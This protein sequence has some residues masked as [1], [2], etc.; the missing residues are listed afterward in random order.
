MCALR[1]EGANLRLILVPRHGERRV[2]IGA[3]LRSYDG[4]VWAFRS[5]GVRSAV[6]VDVYI[7][8]TVGELR[9]FLQMAD[10]AVIGKSFPPHGQGQTPVESAA[11]GIPMIYG[12][13]MSNFRAVCL[14]LE[15]AGG[16]RKLKDGVS[17]LPALRELLNDPESA[18]RMSEAARMV[19]ERNRG[20]LDRTITL[21]DEMIQ[22]LP[23]RNW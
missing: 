7:V 13:S 15:S 8:D 1:A 22:S 3:L 5:E 23:H 2:E 19:F 9:R 11:L 6:P 18:S 17:L 14:E 16:A 21:L 4:L 20:S 10:V 12:P